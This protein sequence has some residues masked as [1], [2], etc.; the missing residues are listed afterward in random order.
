MCGNELFGIS[1]IKYIKM[2][3]VNL[4]YIAEGLFTYLQ[5]LYIVMNYV[6]RWYHVH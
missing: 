4:H 3:L 1:N 2:Y 5:K 6:F